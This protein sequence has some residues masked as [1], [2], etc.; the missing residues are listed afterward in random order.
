MNIL[1]K[2]TPVRF[3][4]AAIA[5]GLATAVSS[6]A[7][8][9]TGT[10]SDVAAG[11]GN[12]DYTII[13]KNTGTLSLNSFWYG[14]TVNGNNLPSNPISAANSLGWVNTLDGNSIQWSNGGTGTALAPG[15]SA[16][17]TFLSSSTLSAI[18]TPPSGDSVAYVG[19]IQFNQGVSGESSPVFFPT[20]APV[21]EP[22]PVGL[23]AAGLLIL[24]ASFKCQA[25]SRQLPQAA[26]GRR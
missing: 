7:Q 1:P 25:G 10:I 11:G 22:S 17:F 8:Q 20:I 21:P 12:F 15:L 18:T 26:N 2:L 23:L 16:T 19:G 13:L 9:A 4:L 3:A 6:P 5:T 24:A 14:W